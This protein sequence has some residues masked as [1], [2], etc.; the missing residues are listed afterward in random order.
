MS[1]KQAAPSDADGGRVTI[2]QIAREAGVSVPTV[3]RVVNG[4]DD[5][6]P[7]TRRRIE[8]LLD[9][10]GY[11]RPSR[12]AERANLI[13]VVFNDLDSPWAV[14]I[15]R[16]IED[17]G[18]AVGIGTVVSAVH[19]RADSK[20]QW[21]LNV[22]GRMSDGVILVTSDLEPE[23]EA[24][25]RKLHV[26]TVVVDPAGVPSMDVPT[27]GAANWQGGMS[28]TDH[29]LSLG[30]R[31][32]GLIA[33]P[34]RLLCSRARRDGY[35]A[36]LQAADIAFDERLVHEGD[37]Y[38]ESGFVGAA[39]ML[40]SEDPPTA[41]F[42]SSDQMALG[43]YEAARRYGMRVPEEISV[44]GFDDLSVVRWSSPPL[45]TVRQPLY[46]MGMLAART[47][48]RILDDETVESPRVELAT[49]LVVRDSTAP[50]RRSS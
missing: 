26:P 41:I 2:T 33:G 46:E 32:I 12:A 30:H 45:T 20:R 44:V 48:L 16:G 11:R 43:V 37:F 1:A 10:H 24:G 31:R 39:E 15:I 13:D 38:H 28:A 5:V 21:L 29:L 49:D 50:P 22:R 27:I 42:A 14:E 34:S 18:H 6:A 7:Q 4:R 23:L 35:R 17:V 25:L 19:T 40:R 8:A 36:A 3:S 47:V 9:E